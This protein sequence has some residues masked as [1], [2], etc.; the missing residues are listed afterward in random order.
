MG[1]IAVAR[2]RSRAV[3]AVTVANMLAAAPHRGE[4]TQ[5]H[6]CGR[7]V[8][9]VSNRPSWVDATLAAANGSAAVFVGTLDNQRELD[10]ALAEAGVPVT[11]GA[12]P[13]ETV[14]A[15]FRTWGDL[16]PSR[17]RGVFAGAFADGDDLRVFRDHI[18]FE[19]LFVHDG[20][21]GFFAATEAK[22]VLAGAQIPREPDPEGLQDV[23]FRGG[24][25]RMPLRGVERSLAG[26]VGAAGEERGVDWRL[27]WDPRH[28]LET[29][30]LTVDEA[31][32]RLAEL[33]EQAVRRSLSGSDAVLLS[34][35]VDSPMVAAFA[36][37]VVL[38]TTGQPL[39]AISASY[40]H[41][42]EVDEQRYVRL[43]ADHLGLRLHTYRATARPL[44]DVEFWARLQ[45]APIDTVSIP[46][47]AEAY[48]TA[49]ELGARTVLGGEFAE[50]V[51]TMTTH[52]LA[53]LL[54]HGRF[55]A[56]WNEVRLQRRRG[57]SWSRILRP[58]PVSMSP[59][60][61]ATRYARLRNRRTVLAPPWVD[62]SRLG[63]QTG[64]PDLTEPARRRWLEAQVA[65]TGAG[66]GAPSP[67]IEADEI[68]AAYHGV[69]PR[70]P[71]VDIDLWEFALSLP[72]QVKFPDRAIK[73]LQR[74]VLDGRVPHEV[75]WRRDKTTF[76]A[77][78][79]DTADY[80]L[81]QR[82]IVD[83][84]YRLD[85]IDYG[86]LAQRLERRELQV[87]ELSWAQDVARVHAFLS[88][89]E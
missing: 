15:A 52:L 2:A 53:H 37:P 51:F 45:D 14:L 38:E 63:V 73:T 31:C 77:H 34:G 75:V 68:A 70:R 69:R 8:L 56:A 71:F 32:E 81:L 9:G 78:M 5:V 47:T 20:A 88:T 60:A 18:G 17:F 59:P 4:A 7:T 66:V 1:S 19:T 55:R 36:A 29:A 72:A 35:G 67:T 13:A 21:D 25:T 61:L 30:D 62:A 86:L 6:V 16:A 58:L 44:D 39:L 26:A 46:E 42:P 24:G 87:D 22:Q 80:P 28:L 79:V 49:A 84:P 54:L 43:V 57:R 76:D 82:L 11:E 50:Y 64:R 85:G 12:A 3:D 33:W 10:G 65:P 48:R 23:L 40:P 27:Y 74:R 41:L 89:F 83:S